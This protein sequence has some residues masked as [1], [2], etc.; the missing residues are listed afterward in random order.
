MGSNNGIMTANVGTAAGNTWAGAEGVSPRNRVS[1]L[2]AVAIVPAGRDDPPVGRLDRDGEDDV[3]HGC[4]RDTAAAEGGVEAA[5]GVVADDDRLETVRNRSKVVPP[6]DDL[7]VA[8]DDDV[9]GVT[10]VVVRGESR[11]DFAPRAK[12]RVQG[13][14]GV[15]PD[16]VELT[17][18]RVQSV[19]DDLAVGLDRD[20]PGVAW[21]VPLGLG[22]VTIPPLP[23]VG[24]R[25]PSELY[26]VTVMMWP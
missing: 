1:E 11:Q 9:V 17:V 23:N 19:N 10:L 12:G 7:A 13:A 5:I 2:A 16:E 21:V 25:D 18:G 24:S 3:V 4:G 15:E 14:V 22:M 26:R 8:L 6:D 20:G